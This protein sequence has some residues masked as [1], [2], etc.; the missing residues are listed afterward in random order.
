MLLYVARVGYDHQLDDFA[1]SSLTPSTSHTQL[2]SLRAC[3]VE[4]H[5]NGVFVLQNLCPYPKYLLHFRRKLDHPRCRGAKWIRMYGH[6]RDVI[7]YTVS[8][9]KRHYI[10]ASDFTK[11]WPIFKILSPT[12]VALNV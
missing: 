8:G 2:R 7:I 4:V 11:C 5:N 1:I 10:F 9:K 6:T 3:L 12:D